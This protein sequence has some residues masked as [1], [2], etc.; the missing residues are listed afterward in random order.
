[1]NDE[2]KTTLVLAGGALMFLGLTTAFRLDFWGNPPPQ[3]TWPLVDPAFTNTATVRASAAERL[4]G[5]GDAGN[6]D[7]SVCHEVD[8]P[9]KLSFDANGRVILPA[10][11]TDL[12]MRHGRN[13]RND[14]CYNCHDE[15]N[16]ALLRQRDGRKLKLEESTQLCAGCHGPT[17][18]DWEWGLHGRVSGYWQRQMGP[19]TKKDCASCHDPHAPVFPSM[20]PAPPPHP[21]HAEAHSQSSTSHS[22]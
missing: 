15:A 12:V 20:K 10:G 4:R 13:Q 6:L 19:A 1:M 8:K 7:C 3:P 9:G 18:R 22:P 2:I 16:H 11:H 17:Y 14:N 21:L 5:N